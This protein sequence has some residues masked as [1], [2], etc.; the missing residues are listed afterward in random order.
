MN[1]ASNKKILGFADAH[2]GIK[3][4]STQQ[5][6]GLF[7]AEIEARIALNEVLKRFSKD[8]IEIAI[9]AGD[10]FH[11]SHPTTQNNEFITSWIEKMDSFGKPFLIIPGNHC[12][13]THSH[14][15]EFISEM[16][17]L[18][19]IYIYDSLSYKSMPK[20]KFFDWDIVIVP[21]IQSI[22]NKD[23]DKTTFNAVREAI[24]NISNKT[25][26]VSHIQESSCVV[27]S[28]STMISKYVDT[29]DFNSMSQKNI[30]ALT[31]HIHK[32]QIYEKRNGVVVVYPGSLFYLD[33]TDANQKKGY[34]LIDKDGRINFEEIKSI[35]KFVYYQIPPL[36]QPID[37]LKKIRLL[38]NQVIFLSVFLDEKIDFNPI[39]EFLKTKECLLGNIENNFNKE[40]KFNITEVSLKK[41]NKFSVFA[42]TIRTIKEE[43]K[44]EY[45]EDVLSEGI[46]LLEEVLK[47]VNTK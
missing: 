17:K 39:R 26:F 19:N 29:V 4:H 16:K 21:Y 5:S 9:C 43:N 35:R 32:H 1:D 8:D 34:V 37:Y 2:L 25:I 27:G 46:L 30:I 47:D 13:S 23:K 24:S 10:M 36:V 6:S 44:I 22:N 11:T 28:E 33:K 41:N 7:D 20:F 45:A 18:K 14:S 3:T 40:R 31:G 15:L 38:K 42:D 12:V